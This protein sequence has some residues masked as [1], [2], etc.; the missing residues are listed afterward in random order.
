[1]VF[2]TLLFLLL[3][4]TEQEAA[5]EAHSRKVAK[6]AN[7]FS[8]SV[9]DIGYALS[10]YML[11]NSETLAKRY[12]DTVLKLPQQLQALHDEVQGNPEQLG[13]VER[14]R[15]YLDRA[16]KLLSTLRNAK[17]EGVDP[18]SVT[19]ILGVRPHLSALLKEFMA[20][21]HKLISAEG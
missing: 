2:T 4:Q 9:I 8:R 18:S 10:G 1:L 16:L 13:S 15:V 20:E 19:Y 11:T 14:M 3:A 21:E 7:D 6:M 17:Q 12:D 5:R